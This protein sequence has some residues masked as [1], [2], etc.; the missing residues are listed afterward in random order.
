VFIQDYEWLSASAIV[1]RPLNYVSFCSFE[2][3][4]KSGKERKKGRGV[5]DATGIH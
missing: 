5:G 4:T 1:E 3:D 2:I